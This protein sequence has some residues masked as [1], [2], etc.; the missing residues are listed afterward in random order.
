MTNF[1]TEGLKLVNKTHDEIKRIGKVNYGT[2]IDIQEIKSVFPKNYKPKVKTIINEYEYE[3]TI[4]GELKNLHLKKLDKKDFL[5][6]NETGN[7]YIFKRVI[8]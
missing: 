8:R 6:F 3:L 5:L 1:A 4:K 2:K 7:K